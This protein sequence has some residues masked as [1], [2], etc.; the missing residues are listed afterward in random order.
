[1]AVSEIISRFEHSLRPITVNLPPWLAVSIMSRG[2]KLFLKLLTTEKNTRIF[3][4]PSHLQKTL[5]G[6]KFRSPIFNAAGVFKN[7]EGY[8]ASACQGAGAYLTGTTTAEP[9]T[10]NDKNNIRHPFAPYPRSEAA[11]NWMGLPNEGHEIVAARI[12]NL[13]RLENCP[14]G[15]S[16]SANPGRTGKKALEG[17]IDGLNL[18]ERAGVDFLEIN[19]SCPNVPHEEHVPLTSGLDQGVINRLEFISR[20]FLQFRQRNLPVIVKISTDTDEDL[21]PAFIDVL[22]SLNFDGLNI[23]NTSTDYELALGFIHPSERKIFKYFT[24]NF[25]GG[26]SGRP[27]NV[28]SL[29]LSAVAVNYLRGKNP[30]R[31]F[32]VIRTGGVD[33]AADIME[34]EQTGIA[35]NQWFTGYFSGFAQ[36]G[37][38]V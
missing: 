27:L 12:S 14:I 4:P 34:S 11:S 8:Y 19:E 37:R 9:R 7:G 5:W 21:L 31:E 35:L 3:R 20:K 2:R 33:K 24:S 10:G 17:I 25:G 30:D 16:L 15:A 36:H 1:M 6:I 28:R 18:Y 26:I 23:G 13:S 32:H 38:A 29:G 22:L